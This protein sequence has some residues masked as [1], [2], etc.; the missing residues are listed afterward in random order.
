MTKKIETIDRR[1]RLRNIVSMMNERNDED[2]NEIMFL[3]RDL[4]GINECIRDGCSNYVVPRKGRKW[5]SEY[6]KTAAYRS[7]R[8]EEKQ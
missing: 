8:N 6:C 7:R 3:M 4:L 5:C 1:E 2:F